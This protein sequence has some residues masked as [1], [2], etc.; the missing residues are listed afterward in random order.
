VPLLPGRL[1]YAGRCK[2]KKCPFQGGDACRPDCA[3]YDR[4]VDMCAFMV[5]ARELESIRM[6][7]GDV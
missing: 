5:I 1:R 6:Q 7:V 3:L 4:V 2:M